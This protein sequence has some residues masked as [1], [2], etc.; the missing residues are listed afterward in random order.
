[1]D[2]NNPLLALADLSRLLLMAMI[3]VAGIVLFVNIRVST[4][5]D[6]FYTSSVTAGAAVFDG[7]FAKAMVA[8]FNGSI[9]YQILAFSNTFVTNTQFSVRS[10]PVSCAAQYDSYIF[11]GAMWSLNV[12]LPAN[13]SDET[14]VKIE[15]SPAIQIDFNQSIANGD[16]F[17]PH[18]CTVYGEDGSNVGI[19]LCLAKS[20]VSSGWMIAGVTVCTQVLDGS[21]LS[22]ARDPLQINTTF[23]LYSLTA[24]TACMR[25]NNSIISVTHIGEPTLQDIDMDGLSLALGWLLNYTA[26]GIPA[27]ASL[28]FMFS[29]GD[30]DPNDRHDW[31]TASDLSLKSILAFSVWLFSVNNGG[32]PL[33][34]TRRLPSEFET[35]ASLCRP[36][37]KVIVDRGAFIAYIVLQSTVLLFFWIVVIWRWTQTTLLQES[38]SYPL[39][40]FA[41]KFVRNEVVAQPDQI[42]EVEK[43]FLR[44]AGSSDVIEVL[45][46]ARV[47]RQG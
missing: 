1:M 7:S 33:K 13:S 26:Q 29:N 8:A 43:D 6:A 9:T 21:C 37:E 38:S 11:P 40:D 47:V 34:P 3:W 24:S 22:F 36:L 2:E 4:V 14:V 45:M 16:S 25:S 15:N 44:D 23:S 46:D 32:D 17:L 30:T 35:S 19:E 20:K 27:M 28:V 18:D 10:T 5:Y 41:A 39:V 31:S 12:T 42:W